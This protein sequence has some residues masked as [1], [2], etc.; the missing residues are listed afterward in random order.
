[1]ITGRVAL[2][3]FSIKKNCQENKNQSIISTENGEK[4]NLKQFQ[5]LE[6]PKTSEG[7]RNRRETC[8]GSLRE[9]IE[10]NIRIFVKT[11]WQDE[12]DFTLEV[13]INLQNDLVYG[14]GKKISLMTYL[15]RQT[16]CPK[17]PWY[18]LQFHDMV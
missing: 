2:Y 5:H 18:S 3:A 13:A 17:K 4:R 6:T 12:K 8:A 10:S 9:R 14:K 16:R 15:A 11:I 1:M 7:T